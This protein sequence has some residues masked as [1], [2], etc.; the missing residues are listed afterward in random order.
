MSKAMTNSTYGSMAIKAVTNIAERSW[1]IASFLLWL[2]IGS[3]ISWPLLAADSESAPAHL[4]SIGVLAHDEGPFSDHH[5]GGTDLNLEVQFTPLPMLWSARPHLGAT[6]NF[7]GDTSAIYAGLTFPFYQSQRWFM[8]GFLSAAVHNGPLHKDPVGCRE[9][10]DCGFG[11][12]LLP[13]LGL[14]AGYRFSPDQSVSLFYNHMSHKWVMEGE[15][16]GIDH[17]GLRYRLAF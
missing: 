6:V 14:E 13:R 2:A 7:V 15:N 5:E 11:K 3:L 8:D 12:R 9:D 1:R 16:E 4:I 10:S 17:I